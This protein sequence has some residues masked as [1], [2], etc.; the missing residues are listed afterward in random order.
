VPFSSSTTNPGSLSAI[1]RDVLNHLDD[2]TSHPAVIQ[3][4]I[5]TQKP[6]GACRGKKR[7]S[8]GTAPRFIASGRL[9]TGSPKE[10]HHG[11]PE[12]VRDFCQ[13]TGANPI[14]AL[15]VLL[16]LLERYAELLSEFGLRQATLQ[17]METNPLPN[18]HV[19]WIGFLGVLHSCS[20]IASPRQ[21]TRSTDTMSRRVRSQRF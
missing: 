7:E 9:K 10:R 14:H 1:G 12:H 21:S 11:N 17:S 3:P 13:T 18:L 6:E 15:F 20:F 5:S 8:G 4:T 16:D 2:R 19:D